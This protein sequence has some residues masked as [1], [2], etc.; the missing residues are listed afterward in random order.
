MNSSYVSFDYYFGK[1]NISL[2]LLLVY[3]LIIGVALGML[4]LT[5]SLLRLKRKNHQLKKQL[6]Q[7]EQ[8]IENIRSLPMRDHN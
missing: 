2:S 6:K 8:E 1:L 7:A 4:V 3:T 5:G